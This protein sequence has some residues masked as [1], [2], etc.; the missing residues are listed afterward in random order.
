MSSL[1]SS[2]SGSTHDIS[3]PGQLGSKNSFTT[4]HSYHT[5]LQSP[6]A[7]NP[8]FDAPLVKRRTELDDQYEAINMEKTY[9]RM[10][11]E[12]Y[13]SCI[14][15]MPVEEF[16]DAFLPV[17]S[18]DREQMPSCDSAFESATSASGDKEEISSNIVSKTIWNYQTV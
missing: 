3:S 10:A 12:M 9:G 7:V 6:S 5:T 16:L 15:P 18:E 13:K 4:V 14:G 2:S 8:I 11:A 1:S 17:Q